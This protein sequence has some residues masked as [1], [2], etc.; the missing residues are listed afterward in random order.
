M[1]RL[2]VKSYAGQPAKVFDESGAIDHD[3]VPSFHSS[4][5][6][7]LDDPFREKLKFEGFGVYDVTI[8]DVEPNKVFD[9]TCCKLE[10]VFAVF[11]RV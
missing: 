1:P 6:R 10:G 9:V 8:F 3:R 5:D 2:A 4:I 11:G 7:D